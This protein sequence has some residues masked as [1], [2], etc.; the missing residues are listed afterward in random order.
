MS[1][2]VVEIGSNAYNTILEQ[3]CKVAVETARKEIRD[4]LF[5]KY[6]SQ[7]EAMVLLDCGRTLLRE[8]IR[9]KLIQ[10]S[11]PSK[12]KVMVLRSS[13]ISFLDGNLQK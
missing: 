6:V 13:I 5:T 1:I 12:G 2:Q 3:A 4:S 7:E 9:K 10:I 8:Y 11:K